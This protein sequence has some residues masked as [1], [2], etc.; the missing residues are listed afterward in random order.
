MPVGDELAVSIVQLPTR[1]PERL[2][3][4]TLSVLAALTTH[5]DVP[6]VT[7]PLGLLSA[8]LS[9]KLLVAFGLPDKRVAAPRYLK[10]RSLRASTIQTSVPLVAIPCTDAFDARL[11]A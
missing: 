2:Y 6:S 9:A 10:T 8:L 1:A 3:L 4:K 5:R 7:I 11:P